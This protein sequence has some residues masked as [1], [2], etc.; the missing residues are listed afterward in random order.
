MAP[1]K[2][3]TNS[4]ILPYMMKSVKSLNQDG[5]SAFPMKHKTSQFEGDPFFNR[6]HPSSSLSKCFYPALHNALC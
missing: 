1:P 3:R 5:P 2:T 6:C 4:L